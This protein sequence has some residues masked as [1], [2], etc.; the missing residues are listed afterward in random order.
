[1][2]REEILVQL[3]GIFRDVLKNEGIVL[4]EETTADAVEGWDSLAH[5]SLVMGMEN[6]FGVKFSVKEMLKWDTVGKM[7]DS[8]SSKL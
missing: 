4:E 1:M 8:I 7:V 3:Q 6:H 2:E 5:V